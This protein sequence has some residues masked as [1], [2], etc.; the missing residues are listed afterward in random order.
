MW[1]GVHSGHTHLVALQ[2]AM[3]NRLEAEGFDRESRP[4]H[5]HVTVGRVRRP[6]R[7]GLREEGP[8]PQIDFRVDRLILKQSRLGPGGSTYT[9]LVS[10]PLGG[11]YREE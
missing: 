11:R 2:E 9:D 8:L 4:F 5:P 3:E 10:H 6:P 1:V 7:G